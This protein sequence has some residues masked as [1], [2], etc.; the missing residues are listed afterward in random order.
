VI[1]LFHL[2][3]LPMPGWLTPLGLAVL[4]SGAAIRILAIRTLAEHFRY[5]LRVESG[6]TL[7][8]EGL[9]RC[10]RHPSYLGL[11]LIALGAALTLASV[12]AT[13]LGALLLLPILVLRMR[14]EESVLTGAFGADYAAYRR[15]SWR[16]V[17]YIY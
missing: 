12:P 6:Q 16:L 10:I 3:L 1:D 4:V 17:P 8:R 5:E 14:E 15:E 9:Y 2:Q 13:S 7:V 11:L